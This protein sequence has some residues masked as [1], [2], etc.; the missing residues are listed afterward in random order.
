MS[1]HSKWKQIKHKKALTD[2]KRG[3]LFSKM[4]REIIVAVREGGASPDSNPRLRAAME[5][6]KSSGVPKN[7]VEHA[8]ERTSGRDE[9]AKLS[10]FLYEV[11]GPHGTQIL[12]EG[13]TDNNNRTLTE[14]KRVLSLYG[15]KLVPPNSILWNFEKLRTE[16]GKDY[17]PKTP[18]T[19]PS[20]T[21]EK[22]EPLLDA[23]L[24]H[25]DVQEVYTNLE[26]H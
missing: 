15:A 6:A 25:D 14:V 8:I 20:D 22:I 4:I 10:E 1:G 23:L 16:E 2:T 13:I 9:N 18:L 24:D 5:R 11:V 17:R 21:K 7:N 12:V 3:R 26:T 19:L